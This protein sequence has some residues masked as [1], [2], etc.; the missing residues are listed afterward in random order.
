MARTRKHLTKLK[1]TIQMAELK[2]TTKKRSAKKHKM[3]IYRVGIIDVC[4]IVRN[5]K[6]CI[7]KRI[8]YGGER[9]KPQLNSNA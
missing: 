6:S 2:K 7:R 3:F 9:S 4:Y 8:I 5:H 1:N